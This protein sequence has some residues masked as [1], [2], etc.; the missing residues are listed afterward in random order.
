MEKMN[1]KIE[2]CF[3]DEQ[4]DFYTKVNFE[5]THIATIRQL[6]PRDWNSI[7]SDEKEDPH[8]ITSMIMICALGG[9][10]AGI[11][12]KIGNE[13]WKWDRPVNE[14]N[15]SLLKAEYREEIIKA[16]NESIKKFN[17]NKKAISLN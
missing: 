13:G 8:Q 9:T 10:I 2:S 7:Y 14:N 15:F 1:D 3:M 16:Y 5:N 6:T 4:P 11:S 12:H 17:K